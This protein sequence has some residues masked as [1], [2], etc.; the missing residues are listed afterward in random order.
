[1]KNLYISILWCSCLQQ[2]LWLLCFIFDCDC[3]A[4]CCCYSLC[5]SPLEDCSL[6]TFVFAP[7]K[8]CTT[9]FCT[10]VAATIIQHANVDHTYVVEQPQTTT[11]TPLRL[12]VLVSSQQ[13]KQKEKPHIRIEGERPVCVCKRKKYGWYNFLSKLQ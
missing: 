2:L 6:L 12:F 3:Y 11:H 10:V 8:R 5:C 4:W 1:M 13:Q 9:T 7:K